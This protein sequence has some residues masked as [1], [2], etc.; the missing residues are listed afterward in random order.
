MIKD[1]SARAKSVRTGRT[2]VELRGF[3]PAEVEAIKKQMGDDVVIR[4]PRALSH[5]GVAF[6]VN[7]KPFDDERVRQ[8]MSLALNRYEMAKVIGPLTGLETVGG[9][10]HPDS[11]WTLTPEE[12]QEL[13]GFG[14][15]YEAN[16][17][18]AKALLEEAGYPNGF[19]TTLLNRAVKLPYI[20]YGV[21]LVTAWKK[22][23]VEA[24]HKL[25]ESASWS[26]NRR[27]GNFAILADPFG[28]AGTGDPDQI[29]NK[30]T[31]GASA[32]Y[33]NFSDP[34]VD[35]LYEAQKVE[36]DPQKRIELVKE[37]Q[38]III[39]KGYFLPGLFWTRI[40]VRSAK[41]KNYEPHHSHH[42]NRR[43]EDAWLAKQ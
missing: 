30:F 21:Y 38:K 25:E 40:E 43:F 8:A 12:L 10:I 17:K 35:R 5:W 34:E 22:I 20:D 24:E 28:S 11:P 33:G 37:M 19:E 39:G 41:I 3:P 1:L 27:I 7:Q 18:Q 32:N 31:T 16:L 14:A 23:G 36:L 13:P 42:M 29:M 4:Y 26:K 6:N 9:L 15:D 2:D